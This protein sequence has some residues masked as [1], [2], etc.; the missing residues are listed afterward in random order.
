[1]P[2]SIIQNFKLGLDARRTVLTSAAGSLVTCENAHITQGG[3]I[4]RRKAFV[5]TSLPNGTFGLCPSNAGLVTFG[6]DVD[7]GGWPLGGVT[8]Y[9]RLQH[10]AVLDGA[11]YDETFHAMTGVKWAKVF[12]GKTAVAATFADGRTFLYIDGV[13]VEQSRNGIVLPGY[14]SREAVHL[15]VLAELKRELEV[16]SWVSTSPLVH[17]S[18]NDR[19]NY[20]TPPGAAFWTFNSPVGVEYAV[21][22][23]SR[24]SADGYLSIQHIT[25]SAA[26]S[27]GV[28]WQSTFGISNPGV[29]G[30]RITV[31]HNG[32][33]L[34]DANT[35]PSWTAANLAQH[36]VNTINYS[37]GITGYTAEVVS[38]FSVRIHSPVGVLPSSALPIV[39]VTGAITVGVPS[40]WS[41]GTGKVVGYG[42]QGAGFSYGTWLAGDTWA[43][44]FVYTDQTV[45]KLGMGYISGS[46][47][48][49]GY[50]SGDRLFLANDDRFNFSKVIDPTRWEIQ[51]A[52]AGY[53][54]FTTQYGAQDSVQ[55]FADY[56]GRLAV[57]GRQSIQIW[58][59][60]ADPAKFVK[61]QTLT[62]IG[63]VAPLSVQGLGE[64]DVVFLADSGVRSL[65]VR[66][67]SG[68]AY[69]NDIGS[70]IDALLQ[71]VL[72]S[73]TDLQKAAS[74]S[75]DNPIDG[76]Y[77]LFVK[78]RFY[79]LSYYPTI[80]IQA[81]STY[82]PQFQQ[83]DS[84]ATFVP[85]ALQIQDG[86]VYIRSSDA[87]YA[88]GGDDGLTYDNTVATVE[89]PWLVGKRHDQKQFVGVDAIVEGKW[90]IY[91]GTDSFSG[92]LDLVA[93]VGSPSAPNVEKDST[94]NKDRLAFTSTGVY[95]KMKAVSDATNIGS[96]RLA[97]LLMYNE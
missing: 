83:G 5:R 59:T 36:V 46:D 65:R 91:A 35:G 38:V 58:T 67:S 22:Y 93:A 70:P 88:Y 92:T 24:A 80:G 94:L 81:W 73:M 18:S 62:N 69:I 64:L 33:L 23:D 77:W 37:S 32:T 56:Q 86:R 7:P 41:G 75:V 52:T 79:V 84:M 9:Q 66:D 57:L 47:F 31:T 50:V 6:S 15:E 61:G 89:T 16:N 14:A 19:W 82:L 2:E 87:I 3:E 49:M 44:S 60:D 95:F 90:S 10:P 21:T 11:P 42:A 28:S 78:D 54:L 4:E 29:L 25:A 39:T 97:A 20:G 45:L 85:Q 12:Q 68:N 96:T 74:P 53:V 40:A 17:S 71:A 43:L 27:A 63:T 8:T 72:A 51:D 13:L 1:M 55:S 76:R 48:L 34:C 26:S 30:D